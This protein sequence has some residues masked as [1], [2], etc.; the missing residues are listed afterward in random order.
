VDQVNYIAHKAWKAC[1]FVMRVFILFK[2]NQPTN[3]PRIYVGH[4][5]C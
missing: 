2:K 5:K 4:N 1:H 3:Q